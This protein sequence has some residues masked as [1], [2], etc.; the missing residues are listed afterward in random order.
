M[1]ERRTFQ[2]TERSTLKT[3]KA[4]LTTTA[5]YSYCELQPFIATLMARSEAKLVVFGIHN[6][7][8]VIDFIKKSGAEYIDCTHQFQA[9]SQPLVALLRF[10]RTTR[11]FRKYFYKLFSILGSNKRLTTALETHFCGL[12]SQRYSVYRNWLAEQSI[13]EIVISDIRDVVFQ[14]DPFENSVRSLELA[15]EP[16][17]RLQKGEHNHSWMTVGY[18]SALANEYI[19]HKVS[20]SGVTA[21]PRND[22]LS[23]LD[24]MSTEIGKIRGFVGPVDQAVHNHLWYSGHFGHHKSLENGEGRVLTL[25]YEAMDRV[26]HVGRQLLYDDKYVVPIL[27]QYDRHEKTTKFV[28]DVLLK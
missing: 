5:G 26:N 22:I 19:G 25:Q 1:V 11:G 3:T 7:L 18:G 24:L 6:D 14:S 10:L 23:Y 15:V 28:T 12:Q 17:I 2:E 13:N 8:Q 4:V 16:V 9:C 21:G 27:H 20:C